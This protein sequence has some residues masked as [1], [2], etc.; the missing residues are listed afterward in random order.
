MLVWSLLTTPTGPMLSLPGK[1]K[2]A[3]VMG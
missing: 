2:A 3:A 1:K